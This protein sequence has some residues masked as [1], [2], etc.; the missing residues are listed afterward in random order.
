MADNESRHVPYI[1]ILGKPAAEVVFIGRD[2]SPNT[3]QVVGVRGGRS[4]FINEIFRLCDNAG[5]TEDSFFITDLCKCHWRTSVG[6]P[7]PGTEDRG[8]KLDKDVAYTCF[9]TWLVHELEILSPRL[10]IAFGEELYQLLRPFITTPAKPP[11]KLSLRRDKSMLDAE[12]WYAENGC[13]ELGLGSQRWPLAVL[14]HPGNSSR[15]GRV[16]EGDRRM[17][18]HQM[19]TDRTVRY[20]K[21]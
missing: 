13:M 14:R 4:V 12:K 6:T 21:G 17:E 20:L 8:E 10:V 18:F 19:A 16:A 11:V 5:I 3:A 2:P 9:S 7:Y 15:L 1:P